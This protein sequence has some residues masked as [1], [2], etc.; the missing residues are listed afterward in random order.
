[1]DG[2]IQLVTPQHKHM[3]LIRNLQCI[4]SR[5]PFSAHPQTSYRQRSVSISQRLLWLRIKFPVTI[6]IVTLC[7]R[8]IITRPQTIRRHLRKVQKKKK[9]VEKEERSIGEEDGLWS[10]SNKR[11]A[12]GS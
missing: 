1:M 2:C 4:Y 12:A 8:L 7:R 9:L 3:V 6:H 11:E 5:L 10:F